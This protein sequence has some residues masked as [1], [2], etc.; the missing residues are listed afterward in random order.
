MV[1]NCALGGPTEL[2][3][4][5]FRMLESFNMWNDRQQY[6]YFYAA[7]VYHFVIRFAPLMVFIYSNA[8][9]L[10]IVR[11][12]GECVFV[13]ML[14]SVFFGYLWRLPQ[15]MQLIKIFRAVFEKCKYVMG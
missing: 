9:V 1:F 14:Y 2:F 10:G 3:P 4:L 8:T 7:I 13:A 11:R 12:L 6:Y 5:V 15:L